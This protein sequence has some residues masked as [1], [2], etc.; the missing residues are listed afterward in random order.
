VVLSLCCRCCLAPVPKF[1]LPCGARGPSLVADEEEGGEGA[2]EKRTRV[3]CE[4]LV[5]VLRELRAAD[6]DGLGSC[7]QWCAP[8]APSCCCGGPITCSPPQETRPW[9]R[10]RAWL[11]LLWGLERPGGNWRELG[12]DGE[13]E[14]EW[15]DLLRP[16]ARAEPGGAACW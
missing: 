5:W 14:W 13:A 12:G 10:A 6:T 16:R 8:F 15:E 9:L 2:T 11:P 4:G 7:C 3:P 1:S